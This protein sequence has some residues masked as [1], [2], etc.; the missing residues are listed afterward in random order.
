MN[1]QHNRDQFDDAE[2]VQSWVYE[3]VV[4][5]YADFKRQKAIDQ[6]RIEIS[7]I[8]MA[9]RRIMDDYPELAAWFCFMVRPYAEFST[10]QA[11]KDVNIEAL[12]P[13]RMGE[14]IR[15]RGRLIPG[16]VLP[17]L[18][19]YVLVRCVQSPSAI[20]GLLRF[21]KVIGVVGDPEKPYRVPDKII[22]TFIEKAAEGG[23]DFTP[24]EPEV[25]DVGQRVRVTDGPFASFP[26][27]VIDWDGV[28]GRIR[29]DVSIFG[30]ETP[31]ELAVAQVEKV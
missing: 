8:D 10:E 22:A 20:A 23:Y 13:T 7:Q 24:P 3:D 19:G 12:V 14:E 26:G 30:R 27:V 4:R 5:P 15:R 18:P 29:V 21:K 6:T 11:L 28:R 9:S 1:M 2:P 16:A 25:F 17:V 31:V